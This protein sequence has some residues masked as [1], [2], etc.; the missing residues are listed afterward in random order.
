[1]TDEEE[2]NTI[3]R[4]GIWFALCRYFVVASKDG[5]QSRSELR[6]GSVGLWEQQE[7]ASEA[8]RGSM[9]EGSIRHTR[10]AIRHGF[11]AI[12]KS[13][14]PISDFPSHSM[15]SSTYRRGLQSQIQIELAC[16]TWRS[17]AGSG[18]TGLE[19]LLAQD[20]EYL[21]RQPS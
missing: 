9:N 15:F 14:W 18:Y 17:W 8:M 12:I 2:M 11:S 1:M 7:L 5:Q 13:S 6:Y 20:P 16:G 21:T 10:Q 3:L 4:F 19:R